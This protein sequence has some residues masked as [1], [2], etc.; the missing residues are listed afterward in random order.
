L[1]DYIKNCIVSTDS[2]LANTQ[3]DFSAFYEQREKEYGLD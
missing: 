2:L 1:T 3:L